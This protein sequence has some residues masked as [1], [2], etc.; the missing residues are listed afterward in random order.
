MKIATLIFLMLVSIIGCTE[1]AAAKGGKG[2]SNGHQDG[3]PA[4]VIEHVSV[5]T[6]SVDELVIHDATVVIEKGRIVSLQ[7]PAPKGAK[8]IN[9]KG[10]WLIPGLMDMHVHLPSDDQLPTQPPRADPPTMHFDTQDIMTPFIANGVTQIL[11]MD[12]VPASVGQRNEIESGK[13]LGPHMA[14]AAVVDGKRPEGRI[15]NTPADAR[16]MVRDVQAEGYNFVKVYWRLDVDVFHAIIDE[17]NKRKIKVLGHIPE[18][19]EGQLDKAFVPGFGMVA[20]AEEF[21]KHSD[22]FTDDDAVRFARLAKKSGTW[23]S[24]TL[25]AMR[26][27]SSQARSLEEVKTNPQNAYM[28]PLLQSKWIKD[29]QYNRNLSKPKTVA[30]L[31]RMVEFHRRLVKAL[32]AENVPMVA[33]TDTLVSGVVSG[34]SLHDELEMMVEAGLTNSEALASATRLPAQWLGVDDDRGT[35]AVGKRADLVLLDANP[36]AKVANTRRIAG[37]FLNGRF[38]S[39]AELDAMMEDLAKRNAVDRDRFDWDKLP[40]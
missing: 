1:C 39:R 4:I 5:L 10:K 3:L 13:V 11:N 9:G 18:A 26:W 6:M 19:F 25:T 31:D 24:P 23:V 20:H 30:Y 7:G 34:F 22:K 35:V 8:R 38:L 29:N 40:K 32:K 28:H 27:I 16:Q 12:A 33:G 15:A 36:I 17:A 37:V 21:S 14:L 2:K